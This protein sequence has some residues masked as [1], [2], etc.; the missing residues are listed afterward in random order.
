MSVHGAP[1]VG[2]PRAGERHLAELLRRRFGV[3]DPVVLQLARLTVRAAAAGHSCL[4]LALLD[5]DLV[6]SLD[7]RRLARDTAGARSTEG[8][9][10]PL[11]DLDVALAALRRSRAVLDVADPSDALLLVG[12]DAEDGDVVGD[13]VGDVKIRGGEIRILE[14][15]PLVLDGTRLSTQR[16]H[17]AEQ[18]LVGA[19]VRRALAG[20]EPVPIATTPLTDD[21]DQVAAVAALAD[22]GV[23]A[24]IGVLAGGPGTGKTTTVAAL[25]AARVE[26]DVAAR[27]S[28]AGGRPLRIALAAPTGKA[29]ARLTESLRAALPRIADVHGDE[30]A[31]Q[32]GV[33]EA[34]TVHRLLGIG[35]GGTRREDVR[36][37]H[38][39][40]V[41]DEA[42]M[43]ALPLAA[44]LLDALEDR[45]QLVLVGD[46][47]QLESVETGSVLR[48]L[49]DTLPA[50]GALARLTRNHRLDTD[51]D[52]SSELAHAVRDGDADAAVA[53]LRAHVAGGVAGGVEREGSLRFVETSEPHRR[54]GDVVAALLDDG[55]GG[56]LLAALE[57]AEAGA[58]AAA[59]EA[60]TGTRLLCAHRH[61]PHGA[62][63]WI[64]RLRAHL[65]AHVG[66][67]GLPPGEVWLPGEPVM[68][69]AN[70]ERTG[71]VNGDT[72]VVVGRGGARRIVFERRDGTLL[73]RAA[74]VL[75]DVTSA[76]AVTVHKSQ[77]S[78]YDTVVVVLPPP[79]SPLATRELLYTAI[80]RAR[81]RVVIV[82]DEAAVRAAVAR[83]SVRMGG[84]AEGLA[85]SLPPSVLSG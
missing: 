73:E 70:D 36:L 42:S 77:G 13:V 53:L 72:G 47:D 16:E 14:Q 19:L 48:A 38:D 29:A 33:L 22:A 63:S 3:D 23:R 21:P 84:L 56:G 18:R 55:R 17:A 25:L 37:P 43:L 28:G 85:R 4:D 24:G 8:D 52:A 46:P 7:A 68:A 78:E 1:T 61:G 11:P 2:D 71:L 12:E 45:T 76:Y 50:G 15:R 40:V 32:L 6:A 80:T 66:A 65:A 54:A 64:D 82:G 44:M 9:A 41:V 31:R 74:E 79:T 62:S 34:T 26:A 20:I 69:L 30:V 35:R 39:L 5:A 58:G 27:A 83:P 49:V 10:D 67:G 81:C 60:L 51:D 75:P 59:L 57:A